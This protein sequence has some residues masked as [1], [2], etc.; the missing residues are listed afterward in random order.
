MMELAARFRVSLKHVKQTLLGFSGTTLKKVQRVEC[1]R[2]MEAKGGGRAQPCIN[3]LFVC[4]SLILS[5]IYIQTN[6]NWIVLMHKHSRWTFHGSLVGRGQ[7]KCV[8]LSRI[9]PPSASAL[10]QLCVREDE[11]KVKVK[12]WTPRP[13]WHGSWPPA[14]CHATQS[15]NHKE[16]P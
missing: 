1:V 4:C 13:L 6:T 5:V 8:R 11:T 9:K 16:L 15:L 3:V 2:V 10:S 14:C 7:N 12:A